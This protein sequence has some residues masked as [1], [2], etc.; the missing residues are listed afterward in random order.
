[1]IDRVIKYLLILLLICTPVA[2]GSMEIWAYSLMEIGILLIIV[3]GVVRNFFLDDHPALAWGPLHIDPVTLNALCLF[4]ALVLF[5]MIPLSSGMMKLISPRTFELRHQ[6]LMPHD[7][8]PL[9]P[10]S[11]VPFATKIEFFKWFCLAG[12]FLFLLR[13]NLSDGGYRTSIHLIG[14][15]LSLGIAESLYGMFEFFSGHRQILYLNEPTLV[16]A[17]TGTFFNRNYF[18]GYLLMVIPLS[19]GFLFSREAIRSAF[20]LENWRLRISSIDGK[21]MLIGFGLILMILGLLFSASRMG[22]ASLLLSFSLISF[23]FRDPHKGNRFSRISVMILGLAI[24]WAAWIG[25]D[26]VLSRFL[27][28]SSED[29]ESRWKIWVNTFQILKDFPLFGSGLG[30]FPQIFPMYRSFH[31][32]GVVTHAEND[33]IQL[34][35]EVGL[36][37]VGL[38]CVLFIFLFY[39]AAAGILKL[40]R[41]DPA[42]YIGI[43]GLI[44]ILALTFH[45]TVER[46]IQVPANAF[47]FTFIWAL[48]L[49]LSAR[50]SDRQNDPVAQ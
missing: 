49:T 26:A 16:P 20:G 25:L 12:L 1:M 13:W 11:F 46:N 30:T 36:I 2:F 44:S 47:L 7:S 31:I 10:L 18:A 37:G 34:A 32:R 41:R 48:V 24:L 19:C 35:S 39:R 9:I 50:G 28:T 43:S 38:L 23:L 33:F 42:R 4:L 5:Q 3:L 14:V 17:V 6:L 21:T 22:I 8:L 40:S 29:F 27:I 45:S 15:I